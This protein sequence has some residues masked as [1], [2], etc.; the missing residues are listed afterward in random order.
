M[1]NFFFKKQLRVFFIWITLVILVV[2]F[3]PSVVSALK[4][5][6]RKCFLLPAKLYSQVSCAFQ[7]KSG[8]AR[9]NEI[10][11]KKSEDFLLKLERFKQLRD[12]NKRLRGLLHL[13]ERFG[14]DTVLAEVIAR[15]PD[16]WIGSFTI[17]RGSQDGL[18]KDSVVCSAKGLLGK[19]V[20]LDKDISKVI[21]ITHPA[22]RAGGMLKTTR[23]NGI[24]AGTG[25]GNMRMLYL[26]VDT[27]VEK[28]DTVVISNS[29]RLFPK[30][31]PIG[32]II[33]VEKSKT[34]L[35][36]DA[37][38]KPYANPFEQEEVL[39]IV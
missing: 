2:F 28:G 20:D 38:I 11:R 27:V 18:A 19:V 12:E 13:K 3:V 17:N 36:K 21:L 7:S 25:D 39:C 9:E 30:G 35:Y 32:E 26:P 4:K 22:F 34:G 16:N 37:V 33:S 31:I 23:T 15:S 5:S 8:L 29:S 6:A 1:Q 14:F 10:L 24:I